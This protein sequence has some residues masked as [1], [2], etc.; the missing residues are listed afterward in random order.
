MERFTYQGGEYT[1]E[2]V[3]AL[4]PGALRAF[5]SELL[6]EL[7]IDEEP[8]EKLDHASCVRDTLTL[9]EKHHN[10]EH[11]SNANPPPMWDQTAPKYFWCDGNRNEKQLKYQDTAILFAEHVVKDEFIVAR[12]SRY[13]RWLYANAGKDKY[14]VQLFIRR[15]TNRTDGSVLADSWCVQILPWQGYSIQFCLQYT[16]RCEIEPPVHGVGITDLNTI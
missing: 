6:G 8:A 2:I 10:N 4:P 15:W 3:D 9:L 5:R 1:E 14:S 16:C 11:F 13:F 12:S 7:G